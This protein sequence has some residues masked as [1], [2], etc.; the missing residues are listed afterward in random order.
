MP[1]NNATNA[2]VII[3]KR[4]KKGNHSDHHGGA[5]KVAYA[6]FVT[7]MMAFFLLLWLLNATTE[8]Q[9]RGISD[10]FSP[11]SVARTTSGAGG[12]LGGQTMARNGVNRS[13]GSIIAVPMPAIPTDIDPTE[14][15]DGESPGDGGEA[16]E[17]AKKADEQ[18]Q[19]KAD[20]LSQEEQE[21]LAAKREEQRFEDATEELRKAI[22]SEPELAK[23]AESLV[24]DRTPEGMRIQIVDQD[25]YSM[26][27]LGSAA[28]YDHTRKLLAIVAK[29]V[30]KLPNR[31][32]VSGHTDAT[33]YS[34]SSTYTNW[35]LS[36]D[37]ALAARRALIESGLPDDRIERVVGQA[38]KELLV[39]SEPNSPRNRRLSIVLLHESNKPAVA[40]TTNTPTPARA[41]DAGPATP[42]AA[43]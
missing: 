4:K 43:H 2:P 26:F 16:E 17:Q 38:D 39:P 23:L 6:D 33:P 15:R 30:T 21:K 29:I 20:T 37:R 14:D 8:E 40:P 19:K 11:A 7:A 42:A 34:R 41:A 10:Y 1:N 25:K 5:W 35:E 3:I 31:I 9:R 27:P 24:I 18:A 36:T 13:E 12:V 32:A 28:M 22:Q